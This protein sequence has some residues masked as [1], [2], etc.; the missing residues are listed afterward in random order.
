MF[1]FPIGVILESFKADRSNAIKKAAAIGA[2]GIQMY[3]TQGENSPENLNPS[4]RKALLDE[5]KSNGLVFS[6]LC[7]DLGR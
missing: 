4:D 2:Q 5:V 3:A 6:A 1:N 7:G